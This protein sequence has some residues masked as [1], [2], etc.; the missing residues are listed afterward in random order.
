MKT[1]VRLLCISALLLSGCYTKANL[2]NNLHGWVGLSSDEL[3]K[4]IGAPQGD[5]FLSD[6]RRLLTWRSHTAGFGCTL[7]F[8]VDKTSS[9]ISS[10]SY[11]GD[12]Q[13]CAG[14]LRG[15]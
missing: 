8:Y 7:N 14:I 3:L 1:G 4:R 15:D 2:E 10:Y 13:S 11:R 12:T 9:L 6:G 5:E